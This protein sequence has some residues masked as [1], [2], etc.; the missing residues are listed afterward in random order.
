MDPEAYRKAVEQV[1]LHQAV[2]AANSLKLHSS[3]FLKGVAE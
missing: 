1:D 3:F 2:E